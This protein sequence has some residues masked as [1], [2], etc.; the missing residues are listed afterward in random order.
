MENKV[1][2]VKLCTKCGCELASDS[3]YKECEQCRTKGIKKVGKVFAV[4]GG[5]AVTCL[6]FLPKIIKAAVKK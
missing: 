6:L 2:N 1:L 3:K 5:V 4:V